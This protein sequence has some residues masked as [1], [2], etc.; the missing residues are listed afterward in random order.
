MVA[1]NETEKDDMK[2]LPMFDL[3]NVVNWS[4]SLKMWLMRKKKSPGFEGEA[5]TSST[6][7]CG[8]RQRGVQT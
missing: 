1:D 5:G 6:G 8:C 7:C 2:C 3:I 4:K